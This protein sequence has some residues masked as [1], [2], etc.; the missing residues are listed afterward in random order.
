MLVRNPFR[1][2]LSSYK[3]FIH[4][5]H[6]FTEVN[7]DKIDMFQCHIGILKRV[8]LLAVYTILEVMNGHLVSLFA[9]S[10]LGQMCYPRTVLESAWIPKHP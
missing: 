10:N 6:S 4:G 3:H 9:A 7:H 8:I 1:A 2:I 5:I